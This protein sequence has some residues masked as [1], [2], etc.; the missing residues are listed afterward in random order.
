MRVKIFEKFFIV[1]NEYEECAKIEG[2][3]LFEL[4]RAIEYRKRTSPK[5]DI[6]LACEILENWPR[7]WLDWV[8]VKTANK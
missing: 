3:M 7:G 2:K 8:D 1:F 5:R 4:L 6:T